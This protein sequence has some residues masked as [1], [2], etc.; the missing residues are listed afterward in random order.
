LVLASCISENLLSLN[1]LAL[2]FLED[3]LVVADFIRITVNHLGGV[4]IFLSN[5]LVQTE[6]HD[7]PTETEEEASEQVVIFKFEGE[8][9]HD[10]HEVDEQREVEVVGDC[11][12][13]LSSTFKH[14]EVNEHQVVFVHVILYEEK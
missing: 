7:G 14:F 9:E 3:S 11:F 4:Y 10:E 13:H 5:V 6:T 12:P 1:E 8:E 2:E